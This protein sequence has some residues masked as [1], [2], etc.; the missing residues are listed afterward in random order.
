MLPGLALDKIYQY[1]DDSYQRDLLFCMSFMSWNIIGSVEEALDYLSLKIGM[2]P[3]TVIPPA[4]QLRQTIITR[5]PVFLDL[6]NGE[7]DQETGPP[8][9]YIVVFNPERELR[10]YQELLEF[11][12]S[13]YN[14]VIPLRNLYQKNHPLTKRA[15][16]KDYMYDHVYFERG[17][18]VDYGGVKVIEICYGS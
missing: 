1:L 11:M 4:D 13:Q 17:K 15:K 12:E 18:L 16:L 10:T 9:R 14:K 7:Y 5:R 8:R 3:D 6:S 2:N